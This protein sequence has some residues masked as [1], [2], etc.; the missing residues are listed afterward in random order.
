MRVTLFMTRGMSLREWHKSGILERELLLYKH[1]NKNNIQVG[2]VTYGGSC[3]VSTTFNLN[4]ISV[5]CNKYNLPNW[6]Y[7][8]LIPLIHKKWL[9]GTD[10]IK[11][12][13][14]YG[15][16]VALYA[17]ILYKK[18]IVARCGYMLSENMSREH[19]KS[20]LRFL[21]AILIEKIAFKKSNLISA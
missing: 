13:Q 4:G 19:G 6:L 8:L 17:A 5:L 10:I 11:T 21:Y 18:P 16:D 1:L 3:D 7:A 14:T 9:K 2:I 15:A 12:N 20:S